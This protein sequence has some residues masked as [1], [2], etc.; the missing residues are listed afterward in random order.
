MRAVPL[1]FF[2]LHD[3]LHSLNM[4]RLEVEGLCRCVLSS[5]EYLEQVTAKQE[6]QEER[7]FYAKFLSQP[8]EKAPR[9]CTSCTGSTYTSFL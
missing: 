2:V 5:L 8:S 6:G 9:T 7:A 1:R 3:T 4:E